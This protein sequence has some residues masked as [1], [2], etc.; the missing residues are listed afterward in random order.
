[1]NDSSVLYVDGTSIACSGGV[2]LKSNAVME[3]KHG[4]ATRHGHGTSVEIRF[5]PENGGLNEPCGCDL[6]VGRAFD[7]DCTTVRRGESVFEDNVL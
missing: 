1:M 6:I 7:K 5:A 2:L 3:K 4:H